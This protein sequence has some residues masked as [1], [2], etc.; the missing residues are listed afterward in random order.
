MNE[1][2]LDHLFG[3][4]LPKFVELVARDTLIPDDFVGVTDE[5]SGTSMQAYEKARLRAV[6]YAHKN[7]MPNPH[8]AVPILI[9]SH[10]EACASSMDAESAAW[11]LEGEASCRSKSSGHKLMAAELIAIWGRGILCMSDEDFAA[12][13]SD[14]YTGPQR[15]LLLKEIGDEPSNAEEA[16]A[17]L[18]AI[19]GSAVDD[20][21]LTNDEREMKRVNRNVDKLTVKNLD[22]LLKQ[23]DVVHPK[24]LKNELAATLIEHLKSNTQDR[25]DFLKSTDTSGAEIFYKGYCRN[26]HIEAQ[27][28]GTMKLIEWLT[29]TGKLPKFLH[30]IWY[31]NAPS[32][33][34]RRANAL[35][36]NTIPK[37]DGYVGPPPSDTV[38]PDKVTVQ[39]M[40]V[41]HSGQNK[42]LQRVG[43][44]R[45]YWGEDGKLPGASKALTLAQ[46][47]DILR[48]DDDFAYCMTIL[49]EKIAEFQA[50]D[51]RVC[52]FEMGYLSKFWC[53]LAWI[54]Q[55]WNDCKRVTRQQCDYTITGLKAVFPVALATACPVTQIRKYM[56]RSLNYARALR[57]IGRHGDF[58]KVPGLC[59][60][61][62]SHLKADLLSRGLIEENSKRVRGPNY[63]PIKH[64]RFIPQD[65]SLEPV[66]CT[67]QAVE[68]DEEIEE[69]V[70]LNDNGG[71]FQLHDDDDSAG[72]AAAV[73]CATAMARS[74][75]KEFE[76]NEVEQSD[77]WLQ[78]ALREDAPAPGR[79]RRYKRPLKFRI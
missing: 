54:E 48:K 4:C 71:I 51:E 3:T 39:R 24:M 77:T 30:F 19:S 60:Q 2:V 73:A 25:A 6:E 72:D 5:N 21:L 27:L 49:Q 58:S 76:E 1:E 22:G 52:D 9:W 33:W 74:R 32:H 65:H 40:I 28:E 78:D 70:E 50:R 37:A 36:V 68:E 45:N 66:D 55:Y 29:K 47:R 67:G 43:Y 38:L 18:A 62:K 57:E 59:R 12:A 16:A 34:K 56:Q 23:Y 14:G 7:Q 46:M 41:E 11:G 79:F 26:E 61:Y 69:Q 44:E 53:I 35:N 15:S 64:A 63:G 8:D 20:N 42:G 75:E 17:E 13:V 31:D 10:D